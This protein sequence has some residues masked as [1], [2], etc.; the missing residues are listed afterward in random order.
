MKKENVLN[1][2]DFLSNLKLNKF[3]KEIRCAIVHNSILASKIVKDIQETFDAAR[4]RFNEE[5]ETE[6]ELLVKYRDQYSTAT[7]EEKVSIVKSIEKECFNALRAE[8][9][10]NEFINNILLEDVTDEFV[11]IDRDSFIDQC[12]EADIDIT[13]KMLEN[14]VELFK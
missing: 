8:R 7:A 9:E 1:F 2:N 14:L 11:K 12:A 13:A 10:L 5:N 3:D 4:K 6:I